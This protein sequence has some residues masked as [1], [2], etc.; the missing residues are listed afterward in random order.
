MTIFLFLHKCLEA[1]NSDAVKISDGL[2]SLE[3]LLNDRSLS[4][5][6]TAS[7]FKAL[8]HLHKNKN[9]VIQKADKGNTIV[10]LE[11]I[12]DISAIEEILKDHTKFSN[13]DI[14]ASIEINYIKKNREKK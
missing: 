3:K 1:L 9:V 13:L 4:E 12:S 6:L 10:I 5:N 11:K 8:R 14:P 2:W 7:E